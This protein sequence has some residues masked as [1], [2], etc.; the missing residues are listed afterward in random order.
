MEQ[1]P[2]TVAGYLQFQQDRLQADEAFRASDE[3]KIKQ[4]VRKIPTALPAKKAGGASGA[5]VTS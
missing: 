1:Q 2:P 5:R 4:A 3:Y